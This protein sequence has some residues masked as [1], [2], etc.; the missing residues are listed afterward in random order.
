MLRGKWSSIKI[1]N[2]VYLSTAKLRLPK[3]HAK[4]LVPRF[5]EPHKVTYTLDLSDD[6]K[7]CHIHPV[8]HIS[9]LRRHKPNDETLFPHR[10]ANTFY[11]LGAP[12]DLEWTVDRILAHK[13]RGTSLR[14]KVLWSLGDETWEPLEGVDQ[15][16]ALDEYLELQGVREVGKLP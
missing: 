10:E 4:K 6:L 11:D 5:I 13:G 7:K 15:L 3:G 2:R 1:G 12:G 9:R 8:F 16:R 14:F